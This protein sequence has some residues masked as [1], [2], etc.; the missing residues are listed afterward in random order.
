MRP[1][2][3]QV[4]SFINN[5]EDFRERFTTFLG[6]NPR[7]PRLI[8]DELRTIGGHQPVEALMSKLTIVALTA[9]VLAL[10]VSALAFVARLDPEHA[11]RSTSATVKPN[12]MM[13]RAPR[14]LPIE[15]YQAH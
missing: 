5:L 13:E 10:T 3:D 6:P 9:I 15:Q 2:S 1:P 14:N 11:G 12:E 7:L 8:T 4:M